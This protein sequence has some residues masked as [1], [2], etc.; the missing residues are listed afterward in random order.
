MEAVAP[1]GGGGA[2]TLHRVNTFC[3]RGEER[4]YHV[5]CLDL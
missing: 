4:L 2:Y 1:W 5:N 3:P